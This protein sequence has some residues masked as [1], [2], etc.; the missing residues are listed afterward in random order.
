MDIALI[1][2]LYST[3]SRHGLSVEIDTK[4]WLDHKHCIIRNYTRSS[5]YRHL[6]KLKPDYSLQGSH[7]AYN[8]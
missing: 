5:M 8:K 2:S 7:R 1:L 4:S 3:W 6:L